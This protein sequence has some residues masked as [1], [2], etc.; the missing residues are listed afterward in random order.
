MER[1]MSKNP[2]LNLEQAVSATGD[3]KLAEFLEATRNGMTVAVAR[4]INKW[5]TDNPD[6]AQIP[7]DEAN[8]VTAEAIAEYRNSAEY[9]ELIDVASPPS[10]T[11]EETR[12]ANNEP[13]LP[14]LDREG[15]ILERENLP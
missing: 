5:Y 10:P 7:A 8:I 11:V 9:K 4:A 12:K 2:M 1:I 6:A 15:E 3:Q 14:K 13:P